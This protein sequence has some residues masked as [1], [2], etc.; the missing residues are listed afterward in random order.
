MPLSKISKRLFYKTDRDRAYPKRWHPDYYHLKSLTSIIEHFAAKYVSKMTDPILIDMGCGNKPY[1][2]I[3]DPFTIK[4]IGLDLPSNKKA[5]IFLSPDGRAPL[6]DNYADI[7][8]S[9]QVLEH[10]DSPA[11][12]LFEC[13]RLL[14][15]G[16]LIIL[17]THGYWC[18]HPSPTDFWRWTGPGIKKTI[19]NACFKTI[20][21][22]GIMSIIPSAIQL[23]QL[24][25]ENKVNKFRPISV[26][27]YFF[28]QLFIQFLDNVF[29]GDRKVDASTF[30]ILAQK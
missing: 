18:Y 14:K 26:C 19:E 13:Y 12:Y 6:S 29:S 20:E 2:S 8:L 23:I 22:Q 15:P 1:L 4:Y 28:M 11:N 3:L 17:S 5:D 16:G 27:F 24:A 10:V 30:V 21:C 9:T 7:I 25:L